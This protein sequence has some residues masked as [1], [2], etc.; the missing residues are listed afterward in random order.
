MLCW[1]QVR[2]G[3]TCAAPEFDVREFHAEATGVASDAVL[4]REPRHRPSYLDGWLGTPDFPGYRAGRIVVRLSAPTL[5]AP[6][7]LQGEALLLDAQGKTCDALRG[8]CACLP[9]SAAIE[10]R[11]SFVCIS[12]ELLY[13]AADD[14]SRF[15]T[16]AQVVAQ[17]R[18]QGVGRAPL[19]AA[20]RLL[21]VVGSEDAVIESLADMLVRSF[22][23]DEARPALD[24][25]VARLIRTRHVNP[26]LRAP[27]AASLGEQ[28]MLLVGGLGKHRVRHVLRMGS[29]FDLL[30]QIEMYRL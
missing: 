15:G 10:A 19:M 2:R 12:A 7:L 11:S 4:W 13:H 6:G 9:L 24:D 30:P 3:T 29:D 26:E 27:M 8:A 22:G 20:A 1:V 14:V 28:L 16:I 21:D 17:L 23:E 18:D 5:L 25:I